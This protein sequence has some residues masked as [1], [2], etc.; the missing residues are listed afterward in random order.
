[1]WKSGIRIVVIC[2]NKINSIY[3]FIESS[4]VYNVYNFQ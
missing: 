1:M 2:G 3:I 4:V